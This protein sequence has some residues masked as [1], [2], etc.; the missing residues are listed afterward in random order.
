MSEDSL[1]DFQPDVTVTH[2]NDTGASVASDFAQCQHL[3]TSITATSRSSK[4]HGRATP[5]FIPTSLSATWVEGG[6]RRVWMST[7][8][9]ADTSDLSQTV[10]QMSQL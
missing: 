3:L 10:C 8:G 4:P 7:I 2:D 1:G 9:R 5:M 6:R